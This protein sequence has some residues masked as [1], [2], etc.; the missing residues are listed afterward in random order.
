MN[1]QGLKYFERLQVSWLLFWR[2]TLMGLAVAF[3][4]GY[5]VGFVWEPLGISPAWAQRI[6]VFGG[7]ILSV[8]LVGPLLIQMLLRKCFNGFRIE[9]VR[10]SG[11]G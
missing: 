6:N 9:L 11:A 7:Y 1:V 10:G 4:W 8:I 3:A 5:F 2:G